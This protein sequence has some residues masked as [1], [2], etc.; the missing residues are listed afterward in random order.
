MMNVKKICF[1]FEYKCK[2][3]MGVLVSLGKKMILFKVKKWEICKNVYYV[4]IKGLV[5]YQEYIGFIDF[6]YLKCLLGS[7]CYWCFIELDN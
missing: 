2:I 7:L 1:L 3:I 6:V 5:G 4:L